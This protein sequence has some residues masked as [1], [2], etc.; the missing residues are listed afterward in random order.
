MIVPTHIPNLAGFMVLLDGTFDIV[1]STFYGERV[2]VAG[3]V[4]RRRT[5]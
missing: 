1:I 2:A 4:R 3:G 5:R